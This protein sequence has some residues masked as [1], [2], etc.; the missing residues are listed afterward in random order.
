MAEAVRIRQK[1]CN[2]SLT[3][4]TR[5]PQGKAQ[6]STQLTFWQ[7]ERPLRESRKPDL[8]IAPVPENLALAPD[9]FYLYCG[10][11]FAAI[12]LTREQAYRAD[13]ALR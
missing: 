4:S 8:T 5:S 9:H 7:T 3:G 11:W 2:S 6:T 13:R 12:Q 10:N 1:S